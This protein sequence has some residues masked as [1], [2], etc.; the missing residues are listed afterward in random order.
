MGIINLITTITVVSP[1]P[2]DAIQCGTMQFRVRVQNASSNS[3]LDGDGSRVYCPLITTPAG[4]LIPVSWSVETSTPGVVTSTPIGV[5]IP[6]QL[7]GAII[8]SF[9]AGGTVTYL[10]N[11]SVSC[12]APVSIVDTKAYVTPGF[13]DSLPSPNQSIG[14][15]QFT[16]NPRRVYMTGTKTLCGGGT[17]IRIG[18][19]ERW[20]V[21]L[22]NTGVD[23]APAGGEVTDLLP[24]GVILTRWRYTDP[25]GN[26]VSGTT[27]PAQVPEIPAGSSFTM[28]IEGYVTQCTCPGF[29]QNCWTYCAPP[30][31]QIGDSTTRCLNVC[32]TGDATRVQEAPCVILT[33]CAKDI[34]CDPTVGRVEG[35]MYVKLVTP[36]GKVAV[37]PRTG[38]VYSCNATYG[39]YA[40][41]ATGCVET[42]PLP[43]NSEL[44]T[45]E[46]VN[47]AGQL[48][49][50][51][52]TG[53][54]SWYEVT[55]TTRTFDALGTLIGSCAEPAM[56]VQLV[57]EDQRILGD[58]VQVRAIA[59]G[60]VYA[61][62]LNQCNIEDFDDCD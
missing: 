22:T 46:T 35:E 27:W 23:D 13:G 42:C 4:A 5:L 28:M 18:H 41:D 10:V 55:I 62:M 11:A 2:P 61:D 20:R 21:V 9:P 15:V 34:C 57:A 8:S 58:R 30:G 16:V 44:L 24:D 37:D 47:I 56:K 12:G 43:R 3:T 25:S 60:S 7:N 6:G 51:A 19:R 50:S 29:V 54:L 36:D 33:D 38:A 14:S 26:I 31:Y 59:E 40:Y 52:C 1:L 53:A 17:T 48:V 32:W 49:S 39:P 45:S